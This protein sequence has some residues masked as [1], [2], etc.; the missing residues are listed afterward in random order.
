VL[1]IYNCFGGNGNIIP[2]DNV[3]TVIFITSGVEEIPLE[4]RGRQG[5]LYK[6]STFGGGE[7][8]L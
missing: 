5:W 4:I 3:M 8:T 1:C 2:E 7:K 6:L